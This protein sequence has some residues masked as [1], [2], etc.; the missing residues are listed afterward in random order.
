MDKNKIKLSN[1]VSI[2]VITVIIF[3]LPTISLEIGDSYTQHDFYTHALN[4][5][6]VVD[7]LVD[8]ELIVVPNTLFGFYPLFDTMVGNGMVNGFFLAI[9]SMTTTSL[10][11]R[12]HKWYFPG[13]ASFDLLCTHIDITVID[14]DGNIIDQKSLTSPNG[15][16][17][18]N[19]WFGL[20]QVE[21]PSISSGLFFFIFIEIYGNY[22]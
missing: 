13:W 14:L 22:E 11:I 15:F 5:S 12:F 8:T 1:R 6:C 21:K 19:D 17:F 16:L 4:T 3:I 10:F 7:N 18:S 2:F 20:E 9:N